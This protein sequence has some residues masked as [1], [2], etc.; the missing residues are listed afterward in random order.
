MKAEKITTLFLDIGGVLLTNGWDEGSRHKAIAHFN[1]DTK[2]T[3]TRHK[4]SFD[5]LELG[6]MTL[7]QYLDIAIFYTPREF[8]KADFITFMLKESAALE[9]SI[10]YFTDLKK[11][12]NLKVVAVSNEAKELNDYRIQKFELNQLFDMFISSCYVRLRKPDR[13]LYKMACDIS[14]TLPAQ[15]L[16][17]DDRLI[18]IEVALSVGIPSLQFQSLEQVKNYIDGL[19]LTLK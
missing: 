11:R 8:S 19:G 9:G 2:E 7:D 17:I 14:Q 10:K 18:Y 5:T 13:D 12:Y 1:L 6:K 16:Y 4:L 3:E 15:A